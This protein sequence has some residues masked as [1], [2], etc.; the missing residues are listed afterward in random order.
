MSE[1][2]SDKD[3]LWALKH[4]IAAAQV[5]SQDIVQANDEESA[6]RLTD[7]V[8]VLDDAATKL[9]NLR[10]IDQDNLGWGTSVYQQVIE[11]I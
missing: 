4:L 1:I 11:Q 9:S 6:E 7:L 8:A 10:W 5:K 2:A 3:K